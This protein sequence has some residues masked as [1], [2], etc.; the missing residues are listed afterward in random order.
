MQ[1]GQTLAGA[2]VRNS[3]SYQFELLKKI[4]TC[5]IIA[6]WDRKHSSFAAQNKL[7]T[8]LLHET[9]GR[10]CRAKFDNFFCGVADKLFILGVSNDLFNKICN[11]EHFVF[12][13]SP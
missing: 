13:E 12:F 1:H 9:G 2:G 4:P 11:F 5:K 10:E 6:G 8:C 3:R 7:L